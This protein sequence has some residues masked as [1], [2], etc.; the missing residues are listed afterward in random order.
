V[1][2]H[3]V[4]E[5]LAGKGAVEPGAGECAVEAL[6]LPGLGH[7]GRDDLLGQDVERRAW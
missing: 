7:A 6:L 2:A 1:E 4:V 5:L 3:H